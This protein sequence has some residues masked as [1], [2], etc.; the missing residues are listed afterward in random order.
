MLGLIYFLDSY[1]VMNLQLYSAGTLQLICPSIKF[2]SAKGRSTDH[3][4]EQVPAVEL[5]LIFSIDNEY[6]PECIQN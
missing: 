3:F 1:P 5:N 6:K 2:L 4:Q